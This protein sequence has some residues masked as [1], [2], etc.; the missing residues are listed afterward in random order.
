MAGQSERTD[1]RSAIRFASEL[2]E[3]VD[4]RSVPGAPLRLG[5]WNVETRYALHPETQDFISGA[6]LPANGD[7]RAFTLTIA[8]GHEIPEVPNLDWASPWIASH[9]P[10]PEKHTYPYRVFADIYAG[11]LYVWDTVA[12][13]GVIWVRRRF[14]LDFRV[15]V[16]PFRLMLSWMAHSKGGF[17]LH[18]GVGTIASHGLILSGPSGSGK[19]TTS[20]SLGLFRSGVLADDCALL[21]DSHAYAIYA[22]AKVDEGALALMGAS[23]LV[24]EVVPGFASGKRMLDLSQLGDHFL[25]SVSVRGIV[26]PSR[27][28]PV[29][30]YPI[31]AAS[32]CNRL[33]IDSRRELFGG[34]V[35]DRLLIAALCSTVPAFRLNLAET[36]RDV[37]LQCDEVVAL[38]NHA[39]EGVA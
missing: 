27:H 13:R 6:F 12:H 28:R 17:V 30:C 29:G 9:V 34:S 38:I 21:F 33:S 10:V 22:R 20:L 36:T 31:S 8:D 5:P 16:T 18:A 23:T 14:E 4:R 19:S 15:L 39:G 1:Q 35:R 2:F 11:V 3:S 24:T 32:A 7:G 37:L 26:F 25:E